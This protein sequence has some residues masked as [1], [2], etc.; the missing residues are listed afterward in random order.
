[1][2][3]LQNL[4][5]YFKLTGIYF[6]SLLIIS[7]CSIDAL[8][9]TSEQLS[10]EELEIASQIMGESLSDQK[11]GIFSSLNDAFIIP[12]EG[13]FSPQSTQIGE[14][15]SLLQN[16]SLSTDDD[17]GRGN[18]NDYNYTY[19]NESGI[20]EVSFNRSIENENLSKKTSVE[21]KYIYLDQNGNFIN[22][23]EVDHDRIE[24]ID[25]TAERSGSVTTSRK[26]S[27]F[28]R[29]DQFLIDGLASGSNTVK[30][31]GTHTGSGSFEFT[32]QNGNLVKRDYTLTVDFLDVTLNHESLS[33]N[34]TLEKGVTGALAYEMIINRSVNGNEDTKTVNG[35]VEFT[36]DGTALLNFSDTFNSPRI[37]IDDGEIYDDDEFE[38]FIRSVNLE[39]NSFTLYNDD[40][41]HITSDT[42]ISNEGDLFTLQEVKDVLDRNI[43]VEAEGEVSRNSEGDL[44]AAEVKFEYEEEDLEFK[45]MI[46]SVDVEG[47]SFT[48]EDGS[49]YHMNDESE[50]DDEGDLSS[51]EEVGT[52]LDNES[53]IN[54][55][56]EFT[57]GDDGS[58]LVVNV[59]FEIKKEKEELE[60]EGVVQSVHQSMRSFDLD[61]GRTI[62]ISSRTEID[63]DLE[64]MEEVAE[65]LDNGYRIEAEGKYITDSNG[66]LVATEVEFEAEEQ[67]DEEGEDE[68]EE[69]SEEHDFEGTVQSV[70]NAD[71]S[72]T[73]AGGLTLHVDEDTEFDGDFNS[74]GQVEGALNQGQ[75]VEAEGEYYIQNNTNIVIEVEFEAEEEEED[76]DE[77]EEEEEEEDEDEDDNDDEEDED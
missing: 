5:T 13:S 15:I 17:A 39:N 26:S 48:L 74:L 56:G 21:L 18:E 49:T 54:A 53:K 10:E 22:N 72:F 71:G 2:K 42:D 31:D 51:L 29:T 36:G 16:I 24:T 77:E 38:G 70:N 7:G 11:D 9:S 4:F 3:S 59:E 75:T 14:S 73:L 64:S 68:D 30:I 63:G 60:F 33:E 34:K 20:H 43:R 61:N 65:A 32:K 1:M 69:E 52:A 12:S 23:P 6:A 27:S 41:I 47:G 37:K 66:R 19:H 28:K 58:F 55:E 46:R 76:D 57:P 35:T 50:I 44:L 40:E 8:D 62:Q 25:Y 67:D 45:G